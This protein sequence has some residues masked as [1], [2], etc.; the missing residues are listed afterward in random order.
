MLGEV[1]NIGKKRPSRQ[2]TVGN[3]CGFQGTTMSAG[4]T[5]LVTALADRWGR[6]A[7]GA[8]GAPMS[9]SN[10]LVVMPSLIF[11]TTSAVPVVRLCLVANVPSMAVSAVSHNGMTW[12]LR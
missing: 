8:V 7:P 1:V 5:G 6:L 12:V 11:R 4:S 9:T 2:P 10:E 3:L